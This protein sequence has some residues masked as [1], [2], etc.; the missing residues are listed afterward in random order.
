[1]LARFA[2]LLEPPVRPVV[3]AALD[4]M[5]ELHG[6]RRALVENRVAAR[7]RDHAHR[8]ALLKRVTCRSTGTRTSIEGSARS[9]TPDRHAPQPGRAVFGP[10]ASS[11][12]AL[13]TTR[14]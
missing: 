5:K 13:T 12:E 2:A 4:A 8:P 11:Q 14:R 1:M 9:K 6:A 10:P 7:N 3:S